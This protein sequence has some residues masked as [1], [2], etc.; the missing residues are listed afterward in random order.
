[1]SLMTT[2]KT[3]KGVD[4]VHSVDDTIEIAGEISKSYGDLIVAV[5]GVED[6]ITNGNKSF[7][8]QNG[9]PMMTQVTGLGCGL[10]ATVGAFCAVQ[11]DYAL[12]TAEA[13]GFYG[14]CGELAAKKV[15]YT[16][17]FGVEFLDALCYCGDKELEELLKLNKL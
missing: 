13:H 10:T 6:Y 3:T 4:S 5:S 14:V 8:C 12:A 2:E 1:M 9:H 17:S 16:G 15:K 7:R 11:D